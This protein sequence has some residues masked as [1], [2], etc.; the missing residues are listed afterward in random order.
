MNRLRWAAWSLAALTVWSV[1]LL[2]RR[3]ARGEGPE[4]SLL[5]LLP[6][7]TRQLL[8]E[9]AIRRMAEAGA[10]Q[11]ILL[12]R[13]RNL[14]EA[15]R[16]ADACAAALQGRRS[17][18]RALSRLEGDFAGQARDF[19]LPWRY[20]WLTLAQRR[21]LRGDSDAAWLSG[22]LERLYAPIGPPRLAPLESDPFGL[23]SE[24]LLE[25]ASR[26][27]LGVEDHHLCVRANGDVYAAVLVELAGTR[28]STGQ[29]AA[30]LGDFADAVAA[31]RREGAVEVLRAGFVFPAAEAAHRA[32]TE[33]SFIGLGSLVGTLLLVFGV[34]RSFKPLAVIFLSLGVGC[35]VALGL[36]PLLCGR[37]HL[38]TLV[39]CTS[40]IGVA[41][42][43]GLLYVSGCADDERTWDAQER[44]AGVLPAMSMAL[45]TTVVGFAVLLLLPFPILRQMAV[46]TML[47]LAAAWLT[48]AVWVPGLCR[49]MPD[50]SAGPLPAWLERVWI[51][52]P[53]LESG[54]LFAAALAGLLM[55]SL[56]GIFRLRPDDDVRQL[57]T[58]S[59]E[60]V[61][62]QT[63]VEELLRLPQAGVFFLVSA[64]DEQT[65]L[66]R[67]E[68]LADGLDAVRRQ[69][70]LRSFTAVS[71]F[72]PS[73]RQQESDQAL[74]WRRLYRE[75]GLASRLFSALG[76]PEV[77]GLCRSQ[78]RKRVAPL[79]PR[80]WLDA[81][82]SSPYRSLWLGEIAGQWA[83]VVTLGG[84]SG[85]D[86]MA[87]LRDLAA[88]HPGVTFVDH[89][90]ALSDL[91]RGFRTGI[92]RFLG[93]GYLAVAA[94]LFVLYGRDTWRVAGP[95]AL[96]SLYTL[97]FFGLT[98]R[99][100]NFF[101]M[102]GLVLVL[103]MGIDYGI[104]LQDRRG[105]NHRVGLL[106]ASLAAGTALL[107]FG[108]LAL[109]RTPA[110][111][112]FGLSML[113]GIGC[114][115]LLAPCFQKK[116]GA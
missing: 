82:L 21:R 24:A 50:A 59:P 35:L 45:A 106:S 76:S 73:L 81:P 89:L 41:V 9:E 51:R 46:F 96:A 57:F 52:W 110:L 48:V 72:V 58:A 47:G 71:Q 4:T 18:A 84:I 114:S 74:Q 90:A 99:N 54:G 79:T 33:M 100:P 15:G 63:R 101:C 103:G 83:S 11:A 36:S 29:E 78:A 102:L 6:S 68:G 23:F 3:V 2:T 61:R 91:M 56:W 62:E 30:L 13:G 14:E 109:S 5:A 97:G 53:R 88:H 20:R 39:F 80:V 7:D 40:L 32:H 10:R 107:S 77:A 93:L 112:T 85:P 98:G 69:G 16:A 8:A 67:E 87:A 31:A 27:G 75:G 55:L 94:C 44:L 60:L 105:G 65:L 111:R 1:A 38:L 19:F 43:Y 34:L 66:E 116:G 12:V 104:F 28:S 86:A 113:L 115:W 17:I 64:P 49:R 42:D 92:G 108:L 70:R 26:S 25:A 37:L 22:A 95:A